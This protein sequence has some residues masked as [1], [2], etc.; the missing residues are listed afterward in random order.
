MANI[1]NSKLNTIPIKNLKTKTSVNDSDIL[2]IEDDTTTYKIKASDLLEYIKET[3]KD[4]FIQLTQKG[5]A[6][7]VAPLDSNL[8]ID[9]SYLQFGE[10]ANK[11]YDGAKGKTLEEALDMQIGRAHV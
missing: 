7:G 2:V 5:I 1:E 4:T 8:K 11:I 9:S 3:I 6:D 10:T